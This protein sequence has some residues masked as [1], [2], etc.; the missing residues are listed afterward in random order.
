M[1]NIET[2]KYLISKVQKIM[3]NEINYDEILGTYHDTGGIDKTKRYFTSLVFYYAVDGSIS[4]EK[5]LGC[6]SCNNIEDIFQ[7]TYDGIFSL[8]LN[9]RDQGS[10]SIEIRSRNICINGS[11]QKENIIVSK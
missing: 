7:L 10:T 4:L 11:L 2:V 9:N 6:F 1:P 5:F 3:A 8:E